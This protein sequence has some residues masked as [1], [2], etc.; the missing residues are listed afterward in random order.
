MGKVPEASVAALAEEE[1]EPLEREQPDSARAAV[2]P[3]S[4]VRRL[5]TA[6]TLQPRGMPK[7]IE[8]T[9]SYGA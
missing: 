6:L 2:T 7:R 3:R 9:S 4:I 8:Y 5:M 1:V